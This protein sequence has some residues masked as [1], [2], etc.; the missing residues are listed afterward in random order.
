MVKL[1]LWK[2]QHYFLGP[3]RGCSCTRCFNHEW[4]RVR[5]DEIK[6]IRIRLAKLEEE[7]RKRRY[8]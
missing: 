7:A 6:E 1:A 5:N 2:L 3:I 8:E 4:R